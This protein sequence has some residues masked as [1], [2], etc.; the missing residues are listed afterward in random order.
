MK[1]G[2]SLTFFFGLL[3]GGMAALIIWYYQKSTSAEDGALA[4]L[5]KL[6]EADRHWRQLRG[7]PQ[8]DAVSPS[9]RIQIHTPPHG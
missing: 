6:A 3:I 2:I 1:R 7:H 8:A 5:D 4:L 9:T